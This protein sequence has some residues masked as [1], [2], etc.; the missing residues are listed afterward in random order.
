MNRKW[1]ITLLTIGIIVFIGLSS[2]LPIYLVKR[3]KYWTPDAISNPERWE[4]VFEDEF[5]G[6]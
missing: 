6:I 3:F 2:F 1:K 4:L 5:E